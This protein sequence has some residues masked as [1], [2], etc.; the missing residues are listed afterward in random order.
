MLEFAMILPL[1]LLLVLGVIE[2]GRMMAIYSSLS[3]GAKQAARY[4]AVA[5]DADAAT[6]G[7]QAFYLDCRGIRQ[8]FR[9]TALFV[10]VPDADLQIRYERPVGAST[11]IYAICA[12]GAISPTST[13]STTLVVRDGDRLVIS[14]TTTYRPIVPIVPLPDLPI[15]FAAARTIFTTIVGPTS[16]PLPNPDLRLAK[17]DSPDPAA[18]GTSLVC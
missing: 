9:N 7:E 15:T 8:R 10:A 12:S 1:L 13:L 3:S 2:A 14:A 6:A 17:T 11:Q 5:G 18:P 4:G 16:T